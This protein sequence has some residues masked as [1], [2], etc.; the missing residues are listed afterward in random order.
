MVPPKSHTI[1]SF[2]WM[3]RSLAWWCGLAEF[4]PL[5]TMAKLTC[6]G[7]FES[8]DDER[9]V[10]VGRQHEHRQ[11]LERHRRVAGQ[12]RQVGAEREEQAVD[13]EP[14]HALAHP[15]HPFTEH[16]CHVCALVVYILRRRLVW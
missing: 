14:L 12:P 3:T 6:S 15:R 5:P 8:R 1:G 7:P 16:L 11:S 13:I 10:A 4:G 2:G 9:G